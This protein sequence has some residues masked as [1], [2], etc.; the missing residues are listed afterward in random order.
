MNKYEIEIVNDLLK[1]YYKR[2]SKYKDAK[3]SKR[4]NLPIEKVLKD[5][6]NYNVNLEEKELVN[7]AV[8]SLE[9]LGFISSSKLKFSDDYQK[10]YLVETEIKELEEYAAKELDIT[11]RSFVVDE[12]Q[13]IIKDYKGKGNI[14]D[15]CINEVE[16][17]IQN[18][19]IPLDPT[20]EEDILKAL[21]FLENNKEFLY[22]REA[23]MKIYGDSKY[24][25]TKRRNQICSVISQYFCVNGEDVFEDEN[26]FERFNIYDT[27]QEICI[28]GPVELDLN[29]KKIDIN[30]L[31]GG[32]SFSIKDIDQIINISINC[33]RVMTVE[34]KTSFLRMG[35]KCC[36][37]YLGG[38]ATKPQ[39]K[40]IKKIISNNPDKE[41]L[42]FGDIDSGGFWIH[43][44]LCEKTG[45]IFKTFHMNK[46]DLENPKYRSCLKKLTDLDK[47]RLSKLI[48]EK[49]YFD[50]I[51]YMLN[52]D[53]KLE[54]EIISLDL[55]TRD[56]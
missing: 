6:S 26:L 2:K 31:I 56:K 7:N 19:F 28:K 24:L 34:N 49:I 11:P 35:G 51:S 25:E 13:E 50:C 33:N 4:I 47:N 40:F 37:I 8:H 43:K 53:V 29:G 36:Y 44:K 27:D 14:V 23:S 30:G 3:I 45:V 17:M 10:V 21:S 52:N 20:K 1:K 22:L 9:M 12:L 41:Y 39:I 15:F 48:E 18:S 46:K 32:V 54:Q 55:S 42:H 16:N 5:Y 38:F